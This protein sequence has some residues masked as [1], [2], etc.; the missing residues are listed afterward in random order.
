MTNERPVVYRGENS[1]LFGVLHQ[2][3]PRH[4]LRHGV[5]FVPG[6]PDFL[7]GDHSMYVYGARQLADAGFHCLVRFRGTRQQRSQRQIY[8]DWRLRGERTL[9]GK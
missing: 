9:L 1:Q 5:L 6:E 2:P 7:F 8:S 4:D 3:S